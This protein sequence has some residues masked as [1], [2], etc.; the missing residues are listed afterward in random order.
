M[1]RI[2]VFQDDQSELRA[3]KNERGY[4]IIDIANNS[5]YFD[6][7]FIEIDRDDLLAFISILENIADEIE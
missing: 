2:L 4:C 3:F 6:Q 1:A 7:N 5:D